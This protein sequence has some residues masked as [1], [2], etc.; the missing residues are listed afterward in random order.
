MKKNRWKTMISLCMAGSLFVTPVMAETSTSTEQTSKTTVVD[1]LTGH[2]FETDMRN[3]I[4]QG[5][6]FGLSEGKYGPDESLTRAQFT[7]FLVRILN[8]NTGSHELT[9]TDVKDD[10]WYSDVIH[11]AASNGLIGGYGDGSFKPNVPISREQMAALVARALQHEKMILI[12]DDLIFLDTNKI[13]PI[14]KDQIASLVY[15]KIIASGKG[16]DF[17]PKANITRGETSAVL[18]RMIHAINNP[19]FITSSTEYN[20]DFNQFV[21]IQMTRT[22]KADG[23]GYYLA[24]REMVKYYANPSNFEKG[25]NEYLQFVRLSKPSGIHV[26]EINTSILNNVGT[27]SNQGAAFIE[28]G[29]RYQVNEIYLI[30]HALHETGNGSSTLSRGIPVDDNGDIQYNVSIDEDGNEKKTM[31]PLSEAD[32][33]V[34]NYFG[35]GAHDSNPLAGGAKYAFREGWFT[36]RDAIIGGAKEIVKNYISAGQ[37]TLYKMRWNPDN[38]GNHQYATHTM[39]AVI[40]TTKMARYYDLIDQ[41]VLAYDVPRF[42]NQPG[43]GTKPTGAAIYHVNKTFPAKEGT[44]Y[45]G[46]LSSTLNMRTGPTTFFSIK[47]KL[48]HG[49]PVTIIGDNGGWYNIKL[50]NGTTGWV[51]AEYIDL[52]VLNDDFIDQV[53]FVDA[54]DLNLRIG[55]S[56]SFR[57]IEKLKQNTPVTIKGEIA[58][59]YKVETEGLRGYVSK[60]YVTLA[61]LTQSVENEGE[62]TP[63]KVQPSHSLG[64]TNQFVSVTDKYNGTVVDI[65]TGAFVTIVE[66]DD[67]TVLIGYEDVVGYISLDKVDIHNEG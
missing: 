60:N 50:E 26:E 41:F 7:A 52:T 25:T 66:I 38:P 23:G 61:V 31:V 1:D 63:E 54:T 4:D 21:D 47:E 27:L 56:T 43:P 2:Y 62:T 12:Q 67:D 44:V 39:W 40:Q 29:G 55:P 57:S 19:K 30:A 24:S 3:L 45:L 8:L 17:R 65:P 15:L 9:F 6:I 36:P 14:F 58:G 34:Y 10:A 28:A 5:I 22:P 37:D 32:H 33:V 35:Y 64:M 11:R 16:V 51:A 46:N 53:G 49:T 48:L 13:N 59:W 42:I 20:Q 18:N